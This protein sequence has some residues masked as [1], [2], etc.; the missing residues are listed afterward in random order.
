MRR[1]DQASKE[2]GL[3]ANVHKTKYMVMSRDQNEGRS[4]NVRTDIRSFEMVKISNT[5]EQP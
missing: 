5:W 1:T 2:I 3:E 4:Q